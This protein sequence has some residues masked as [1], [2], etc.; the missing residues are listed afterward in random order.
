MQDTVTP[1]ACPSCNSAWWT[2][3]IVK[4]EIDAR[5]NHDINLQCAHCHME[6]LFRIILAEAVTG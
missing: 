6:L 5:G 3:K 2:A 1:L 4:S